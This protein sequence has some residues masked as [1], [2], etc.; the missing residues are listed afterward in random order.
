LSGNNGDGPVT[1]FDLL[2]Q[3]IGDQYD[4]LL[5]ERE[6][7]KA[8]LAE[9]DADVKRLERMLLIARPELRETVE[10]KPKPRGSRD[11]KGRTSEATRNR[12][13]EFMQT[14]DPAP[15]RG[16][17]R[18]TISEALGLSDSSVSYALKELRAEERVRLVGKL[19]RQDG[20]MGIAKSLYAVMPNG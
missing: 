13:V 18:N 7:L 12:V 1:D 19:P 4:R 10:P 8:R 14:H 3:Q 15:Y 5:A 20:Q 9:L 6:P 16:F 2:A 17:D 11:V